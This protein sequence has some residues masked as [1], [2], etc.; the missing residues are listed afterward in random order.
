MK[1]ERQG[2]DGDGAIKLFLLGDGD[3]RN[4]GRRN[5]GMTS[6]DQ[7]V[8]PSAMVGH[9]EIGGTRQQSPRRRERKSW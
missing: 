9:G 1:L 5:V 4:Q 3:E 8:C 7:Q 6:Q 2:G